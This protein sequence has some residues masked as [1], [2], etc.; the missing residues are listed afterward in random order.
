MTWWVN[1]CKVPRVYAVVTTPAPV[2]TF[3]G[4]CWDIVLTY[5]R[6]TIVVHR[7]RCSCNKDY[8]IASEP[9]DRTKHAVSDD[10]R[11]HSYCKSLDAFPMS[12]HRFHVGIITSSLFIFVTCF[13]SGPSR[14]YTGTSRHRAISVVCSFNRIAK[15]YRQRMGNICICRHDA[16]THVLDDLPPRCAKALLN[17][18]RGLA[19]PPRDPVARGTLSD[20]V[21]LCFRVLETET[22]MQLDDRR[23]AVRKTDAT[24]ETREFLSAVPGWLILFLHIFTINAHVRYYQNALRTTDAVVLFNLKRLA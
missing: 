10:G 8:C 22:N 7:L 6:R 3:R 11:M 20:I 2:R 21:I 16:Y 19:Q 12:P 4:T 14:K 17:P 15:S 5:R 9:S 24:T 1:F 23:H 13:P 18:L